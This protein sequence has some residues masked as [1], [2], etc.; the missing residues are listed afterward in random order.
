MLDFLLR[1]LQDRSWLRDPSDRKAPLFSTDWP[2]M[3]GML[4]DEIERVGGYDIVIEVDAAR[5]SITHRGTL[6]RGAVLYSPAVRV[7][8]ETDDQGEMI[9]PS[10]MYREKNWGGFD[11]TGIWKYNVFAVAHHLKALRAL[12]RHGVAKGEQYEAYKALPSGSPAAVAAL[13]AE[14]AINVLLD[15]SGDGGTWPFLP[16]LQRKIV[17]KARRASHPDLNGGKRAAADM[18]DAAIQ[19]LVTA[20][21]LP[22]GS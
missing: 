9:F 11:R 21:V 13:S 14:E 3:L 7:G 8:F 6:V 17:K 16:D 5:E 18:V 10:D 2:G 4:G 1:P 19:T 15:Q 12:E 20:G 22:D